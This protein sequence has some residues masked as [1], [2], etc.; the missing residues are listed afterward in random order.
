L[1][2][3]GSRNSA[4]YISCSFTVIDGNRLSSC[5]TYLKQWAAE[6]HK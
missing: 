1:M 2:L 5:C 3:S 4:Q 6:W